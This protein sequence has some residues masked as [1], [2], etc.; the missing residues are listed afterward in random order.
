MLLSVAI[1]G[2]G[3]FDLRQN[4]ARGVRAFSNNDEK[5]VG[6]VSYPV[7]REL[8]VA[9]NRSGTRYRLHIDPKRH[10]L[11]FKQKGRRDDERSA[12]ESVR[13]AV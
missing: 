4:L 2:I 1:Q 12:N 11:A 5:I 3:N 10:D 8:V 6:T 7:L 9:Q 13:L